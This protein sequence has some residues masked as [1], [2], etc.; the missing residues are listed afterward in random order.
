[1]SN[2]TLRTELDS[3]IERTHNGL[4]SEAK[5]F[6]IQTVILKPNEL[7]EINRNGNHTTFEAHFMPIVTVK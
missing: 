2:W 1:M 6:P 5:H 4:L 3:R 7:Q